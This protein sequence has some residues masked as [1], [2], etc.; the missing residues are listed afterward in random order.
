MN[1]K[2][3]AETAMAVTASFLLL[4][5]SERPH[6]SSFHRTVAADP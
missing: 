4:E 3:E 1:Q 6:V 5:I 2:E